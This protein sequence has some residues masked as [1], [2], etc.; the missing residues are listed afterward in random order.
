MH[1]MR[2]LVAESGR[3]A[4]LFRTTADV[5]SNARHL[6]FSNLPDLPASRRAAGVSWLQ[7]H[8]FDGTCKG[9]GFSS[10][11]FLRTV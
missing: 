1:A 9:L 5:H 7:L 4:E 2:R 10:E 11:R 6:Q 8:L 3:I